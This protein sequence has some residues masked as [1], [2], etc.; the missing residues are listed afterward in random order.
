MGRRV[1]LPGRR[2]RCLPGRTAHPAPRHRQGLVCACAVSIGPA[3]CRGA[4]CTPGLYLAR[5]LVFAVGHPCFLSLLSWCPNPDLPFYVISLVPARVPTSQ[6]VPLSVSLVCVR[7][8]FPN[9]LSCSLRVSASPFCPFLDPLLPRVS[10]LYSLAPFLLSSP[11]FPSVS[12]FSTLST[13]CVH[14]SGFHPIL[15]APL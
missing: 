15:Q 6:V 1:L 13:L 10:F 9:V 2:W 8:D 4:S 14:P 3:K 7:A 12:V 11:C 5:W